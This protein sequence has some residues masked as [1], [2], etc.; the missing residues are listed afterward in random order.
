MN[1]VRGCTLKWGLDGGDWDSGAQPGSHARGPMAHAHSI[2]IM[3]FSSSQKMTSTSMKQ[4][5]TTTKHVSVKATVLIKKDDKRLTVKQDP[6]GELNGGTTFV[7]H[8][9]TN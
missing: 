3:S 7:L 4:Q 5:T 2:A 8:Q 6:N 9:F 1:D